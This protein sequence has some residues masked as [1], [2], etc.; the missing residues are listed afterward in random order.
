MIYFADK[1]LPHSQRSRPVQFSQF[2]RRLDT[3]SRP[4]DLLGVGAVYS[5]SLSPNEKNLRAFGIENKLA[6]KGAIS[7]TKNATRILCF[8]LFAV[9]AVSGASA[10]TAKITSISKVVAG[11]HQTIR[12][13]GT[14][15]G[16]YHPYQGDSNY[17]AFN[18]GTGDWQAGY[19]PD[20]NEQ[21]LIVN[22]WKSTEIVLGGF[23]LD[24][25]AWLPRAGD[26]FWI[27]VFNTRSGKGT[28]K[29][30]TVQ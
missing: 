26:K 7:M 23:T 28:T 6:Q 16:A 15:F 13:V 17:L 19:S 24:D 29:Y 9:T 25:Q 20:N 4:I 11:Q 30:G 10:Q 18:D 21:G 1:V 2:H 12:I 8:A 14:N 5:T 27:S 3:S 22:S